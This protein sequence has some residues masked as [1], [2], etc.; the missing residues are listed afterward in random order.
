[1]ELCTMIDWISVTSYSIQ[2][3]FSALML[4]AGWQEGHL[5]CK[6][7][8]VEGWHGYLCEPSSRSAYGSSDA[9]ATYCLLLQ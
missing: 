4:L 7:W 2:F 1:M 9:I 3:A 6:N 8:V 5:D